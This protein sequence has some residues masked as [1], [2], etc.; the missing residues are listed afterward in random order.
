MSNWQYIVLGI[1][2]LLAIWVSIDLFK[3]PRFEG[4]MRI[5][6]LLP[7]LFVPFCGSLI[8]LIVR[9]AELQDRPGTRRK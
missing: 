4:P 8:Y 1:H 3:N 7:I 9:N 5:M 2:L 6:F